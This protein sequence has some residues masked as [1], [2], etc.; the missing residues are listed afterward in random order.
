MADRLIIDGMDSRSHIL[1]G[2]GGDT[3]DYETDPAHKEFYHHLP[4]V[5][6]NAET[7]VI[8]ESMSAGQSKNIRIRGAGQFGVFRKAI[9]N[10]SDWKLTVYSNQGRQFA[11][12][13]FSG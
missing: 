11:I 6:R 7:V 12:A 13:T 2:M 3:E 8:E 9:S 10:Q 1:D 4:A 5:I